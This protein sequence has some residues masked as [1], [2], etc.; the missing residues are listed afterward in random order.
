MSVKNSTSKELL[1]RY[2]V[3]GH[4]IYVLGTFDA[5]VTVLDQQARALNLI[6]SLI[7]ERTVLSRVAPRKDLAKP[8]AERIA[9]IGGGFAGLTAAAGLLR[10]DVEA[11]ITIFE[12]RDTLLPLQQGSDS[13]WLHPH[14]YDWPAVG[15]LSGAA[16]LPV[17]NWT[18]ARASDVVVQILG[19]WKKA[20]HDWH[21]QSKRKLRLYCNA[22]HV[23]VHEIGSDRDGL[24]IEWVGEQRDPQDGIAAYAPDSRH[25]DPR[26]Q[27]VNTGSS[28]S[29]DIVILAVGFGTKRDTPQSYWRN[30]TYAQPSLD[31]QRHTFVVSGQ[32]DGA[33]MDLL[34]LRVSQFRQDRILGELFSG[35]RALIDELRRVQSEHTG[36]DAKQGL[37]D[38]LETVSSSHRVAFEAVRA[39][40]SQRLRRDTEVILSLQVKKFS[41][42]FDPATRRIS[43]QNRVLVYLLY[44]CGG[45]FPS[46]RGT[47]CLENE[48]EVSEER[49]VR[50]H[51]TRRDEVL[52]S[53]LSP[54]LY[55]VI[56]QMQAK[57]DGG[58]FLQPH[59]P[60]WT[61][62]YFGFPGR[63][64]DAK[65][66]PEGTKS[67]W[68]KEYLPGPTALMATAFCASLAGALRHGHNPSRRLRVTLH[69]VAS[70]GGQEVLQQACNYQGVALER[71]D[72]SGIGRTFPIHMGTIGLAFYTRRVIRSL[73]S[74][75]PG[76]L[77]AYMSSPSRRLR[78]S[79]R[80]MSTKVRFVIAIPIL[81]PTDPGLHSPPS[82]VA[83][84]I[85]IDSEADD[86]FIDDGSLKGIVW[87]AK[88][89]LDGLQALGKTPLERLSNL[90]PPVRSSSQVETSSIERDPF[91][92]AA[93]EVLEEVGTVEPPVTAGPFQLNFDYSE[94]VVQE[95]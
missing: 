36:P 67:A 73:P 28:E 30:E 23:Q 52:K 45:F 90:A 20:Y 75:D 78:E 93:R 77:H 94:F 72:E 92:A 48:N 76:K 6:W 64:D 40:M 34:R 24:R 79:T 25:G 68:K 58:Y 7:E 60:N 88:G 3:P 11:D 82:A 71:K 32:G 87:M 44:K 19:E 47:D 59:I 29:F 5:G 14:I 80:L 63:A 43:F 70:F 46:S 81:E 33:M 49:V 22:R 74:V 38:A 66:L 9:I 10:K 13:R 56:E 17:L 84:V 21:E 57:H 62:G 65:R 26:H 83:G 18:A 41:E 54:H 69:R 15:S 8:R 35:E 95:D 61:G 85:Y 51:G 4:Q 89:F 16:L 1:A 86:F 53:V 37:F 31:S 50:R 2:K 42:L 27:S 12:Q 91:D 39:R 55:D